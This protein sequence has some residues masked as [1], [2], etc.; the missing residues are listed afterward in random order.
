M[1]A[2]FP[3]EI[4]APSE[5][6]PILNEDKQEDDDIRRDKKQAENISDKIQAR[7]KIKQRN[8]LALLFSR[9]SKIVKITTTSVVHSFKNNNLTIMEFLGVPM[10]NKQ[11]AGLEHL[12]V[13]PMCQ[14]L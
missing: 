7:E 8:L 14:T 2:T 13:L 1:V 3:E 11:Y 4:P 5:I 12:Y 6:M 9:F 10:G